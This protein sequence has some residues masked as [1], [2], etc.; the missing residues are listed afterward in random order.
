[1]E[2]FYKQD[3]INKLSEILKK[4]YYCKNV[5]VMISKGVKDKILPSI[6]NELNMAENPFKVNDERG[7]F[8]LVIAVGGGNICNNAKIYC[9]ER[10]LDL[11]VVPTAPTS[12]IFFSDECYKL[13]LNTIEVVKGVSPKY[14]IV[15]EKIIQAAPLYLAKRGFLFGLSFNEILYE[16]EIYNLLFNSFENIEDLKYLLITLENGAMKLA[17]GEREGKLEVM[18]FMIEVAKLNLDITAIISLAHLLSLSDN[19]ASENILI[20]KYKKLSEQNK[21]LNLNYLIAADLLIS[22]FKE[23][24]S[25]K[26]IEPKI[27]PSIQKLQKKLNNFN[28]LV[29]KIKNLAF[30][31]KIIE[32][33][34][35]FLKINVIKYRCYYLAE[36]YKDRI[37]NSIKKIINISPEIPDIDVCFNA[38]SVIPILDNKNLL[39]NMLSCVGILD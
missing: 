5:L 37:K 23:M 6:V 34:E 21:N 16:K 38:I 18:D 2:I 28:I 14:A 27:F 24:F 22:T 13:N 9:K 29:G 26:K 4:N 1:M 35:L 25:L 8:D 17:S 19:F 36:I 12:T 32:N 20:R 33:K 39:V 31:D 11:I 10:S 7:E 30:F 3:A 15:D